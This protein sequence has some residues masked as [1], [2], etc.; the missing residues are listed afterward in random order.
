[1]AVLEEK[2]FEQICDMTI[3]FKAY[4]EN[5]NDGADEQ[6]RAVQDRTRWVE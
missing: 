4:L 6:Q 5:V 2:D 3:K 1:M